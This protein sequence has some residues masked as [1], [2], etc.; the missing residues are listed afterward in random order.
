MNMFS[1]E[2]SLINEIARDYVKDNTRRA[3]DSKQI[4]FREYC[5]YV[6][7]KDDHPLTITEIKVYGFML[8]QC[9]RTKK[10][11]KGVKWINGTPR[12]RPDDYDNVMKSINSGNVPTKDLIKYSLFN[13]YLCSIKDLLAIQNDDLNNPFKKEM[14]MTN[15]MKKL[16]TIVS[17]RK[18][19]LKKINCDER[20]DNEFHPYKMI[21][22]IADIE[23][24]FWNYK[25]GRIQSMCSSIRDR[26]QFL[27]TL[28]GCLRSDSLYKADLCD[29]C[30]LVYHQNAERSVYQI[31]ILRIGEAKTIKDNAHF[32]RVLRHVDVTKCAFGA[33]GLWLLA[34]FKETGE[35]E[36]YNFEDNFSWFNSKLMVSPQYRKTKLKKDSLVHKIS[37]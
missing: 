25:F 10:R 5:E 22:Q 23:A 18:E 8:Y 30:D 17:G 1:K 12:F 7:G 3:Y 32:G 20:F 27:M 15:D 29:L 13:T 4:E 28:S 34:R 37:N 16:F 2:K 21:D 11:G 26:F 19:R 35:M 36:E 33:L 9:H 6:H 14:I 24:G 31:L